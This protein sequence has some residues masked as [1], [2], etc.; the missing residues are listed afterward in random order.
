[1]GDTGVGVVGIG[2]DAGAQEFRINA[3]ARSSQK[4]FFI[5]IL[6]SI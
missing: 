4:I 2:V 6:L 1:V 5:D 3:T